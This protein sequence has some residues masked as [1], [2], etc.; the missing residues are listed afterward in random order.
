MSPGFPH[1]LTVLREA[2]QWVASAQRAKLRFPFELFCSL[3][4]YD[5]PYLVAL[6]PRATL[7]T[8]KLYAAPYRATLHPTELHC[9]LF[10]SSAGA[11]PCELHCTLWAMPQPRS[12]PAYYWAIKHPTELHCTRLSYD[13]AWWATLYWAMLML[14]TSARGT[15]LS[16]AAPYWAT[17]YPLS[18]AAP[19]WATLNPTELRWT[20]LSYAVP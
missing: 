11:S 15:L 1:H 12:E 8:V 19:Y 10:S 3:L 7:H 9:I 16:Y 17:L 14:S 20:L 13:A 18:Y 2:P 4:S 5:V 6:R